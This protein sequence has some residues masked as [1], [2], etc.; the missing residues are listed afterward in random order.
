MMRRLTMTLALI[1]ALSVAMHAQFRRGMLSEAT[2]ITLYPLVPPAVL[3]PR[4][5]VRLEVRNGS[6]ATAR[7]LEPVQERLARQLVD[8]DDRLEIV[9]SDGTLRLLAACREDLQ[10]GDRCYAQPRALM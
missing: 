2:E 4:G 3:L 1:L 5:T 6:G 9:S 7:L 10:Q 8:N